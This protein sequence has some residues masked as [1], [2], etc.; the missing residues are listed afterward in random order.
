MT[1]IFAGCFLFWQAVQLCLWLAIAP[2]NEFRLGDYVRNSLMLF[3]IIL[4]GGICGAGR[5]GK[6]R[7]SA[8]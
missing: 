4:L 1:L 6:P 5:D 2:P 8:A 7:Q 3:G